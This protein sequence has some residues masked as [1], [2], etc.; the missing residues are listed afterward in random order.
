MKPNVIFTAFANPQGDLVN[1]TEEQNGIQDVLLP[2]ERQGKIEKHLVRTDT[3]MLAYFEFLREYRDKISI[4]H[5][6]GHADSKGISLQNAHIF[7]EPL[8]KELI[9]RNPNA[10]Q[11]VVLNGCC[12]RPH[13]KTLFDLGVKAVIATSVK[14]NDRTATQF[15]IR[16]YKNLAGGD[17]IE[18]AYN[19][20]ANFAKGNSTGQRF[21]GFGSVH[22]SPDF[23]EE[24]ESGDEFPWGLYT[25]GNEDVLKYVF[26]S[27]EH[28]GESSTQRSTVDSGRLA[29]ERKSTQTAEKIYNIENID[30]AN[31]S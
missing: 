17:T 2:L 6:G 8:A 16:F 30:Q 4:F 21:Q 31:F 13:L 24:S 14:V 3:D 15:A 18:S 19:S 26:F 9:Q 22:R 10:L 28:Q 23:E 12:T 29:S 20:A 27:E 25:N 11:L 7:F 1:L 5:Y